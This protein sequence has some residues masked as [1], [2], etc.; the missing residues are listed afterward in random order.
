MYNRSNNGS[1]FY[2][3]FYSIDIPPCHRQRKTVETGT[4][5]HITSDVLR[6]TLLWTVIDWTLSNV[7]QKENVTSSSCI[8]NEI[9]G[10]GSLLA[11]SKHPG[12]VMVWSTPMFLYTISSSSPNKIY[13][14]D[15]N[16]S[17]KWVLIMKMDF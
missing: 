17:K 16:T 12:I 2:Q 15:G 1:N 8:K 5:G 6:A 7:R 11:N 9:A 10:H 13:I 3:D 4:C 14:V